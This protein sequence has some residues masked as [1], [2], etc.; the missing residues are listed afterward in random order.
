MLASLLTVIGCG[1]DNSS[2]GDD[3]YYGMNPIVDGSLPASGQQALQEL[4]NWYASAENPTLGIRGNFIKETSS[5]GGGGFQF[6]A[7]FCFFGMGNGCDNAQEPTH[8][9]VRNQNNVSYDVGIPGEFGTCSITR[10][11]VTKANNPELLAAVNGNGLTLLSIQ[12][13]GNFYFLTYGRNA[14]QPE[15]AY[16]IDTSIH[17][18]LNPVRIQDARTY[19]KTELKAFFTF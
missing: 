19:K 7:S 3:G 15:V 16:T 10:T 6:N 2:G 5:M 11:N 8:C 13:F 12:K 1:K 14:Y 4:R 18:I 9:F 17:S